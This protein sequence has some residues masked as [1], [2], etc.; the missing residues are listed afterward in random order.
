MTSSRQSPS[1][2][3]ERD[4]VDLVLLF[5]CT[6]DAISRR[7]SPEVPYL[8]MWVASSSSRVASPSHQ[9]RK[10]VEPGLRLATTA[11]DGPRTP[12]AADDQDSAPGLP[13]QMSSETPRPLS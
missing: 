9:I 2:S 6:S 7:V 13:D 11:P 3:P 8:S 4:G 10:F 12:S 1:R 5:E